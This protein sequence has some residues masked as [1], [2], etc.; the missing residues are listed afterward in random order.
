MYVEIKSF[1][2]FKEKKENIKTLI[3]KP[4]HFQAKKQPI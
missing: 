4:E 2:F 3:S 1:F